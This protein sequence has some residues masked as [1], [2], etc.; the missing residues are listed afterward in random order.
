[1]PWNILGAFKTTGSYLFLKVILGP[2]SFSKKI[3]EHYILRINLG[4]ARAEAPDHGYTY[5]TYIQ[6]NY[7]NIMA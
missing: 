2:A 7:E 6:K 5:M 3:T 4:F 1:M